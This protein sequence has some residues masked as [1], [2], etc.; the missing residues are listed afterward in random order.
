MKRLKEGIYQTVDSTG[1]AD[2]AFNS[3]SGHGIPDW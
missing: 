2:Q 3:D 1:A